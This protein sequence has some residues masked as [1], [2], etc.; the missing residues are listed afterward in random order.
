[1]DKLY[2]DFLDSVRGYIDKD[3]ARERINVKPVDK[4]RAKERD[5]D[6]QDTNS[7]YND[8]KKGLPPVFVNKVLAYID[9][10]FPSIGDFGSKIKVELRKD[11]KSGEPHQLEKVTKKSR[12]TVY[13]EYMKFIDNLEKRLLKILINLK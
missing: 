7:N 12:D 2:E 1:M 13:K 4:A 6:T 8:G 9:S 5:P 11:I 10:I 3:N